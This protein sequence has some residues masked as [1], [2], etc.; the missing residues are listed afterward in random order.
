[1]SKNPNDVGGI[2][3]DRLKSFV[4]RWERL[5]EEIKGLREDQKEIMA[6]AKG[7]GFDVKTIR[8]MIK[9]REL[10]QEERDEQ[11][12]LDDLYKAALGMLN[13]TPLGDAAVR[14]LSRKSAAPPPPA[15]NGDQ[16]DIED[17]TKPAAN[18]EADEQQPDPGP[19]MEE[20][21][22]MG[23][24]AAKAGKPVTDNPFPARD[25][26]R[27]AWDEEWC[28]AAGSDGMDIPD[29]W[30]RAKKSA[31]SDERKAA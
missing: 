30:K 20:A 14:R 6:E 7:S 8:R 26:R 1:M 17:F 19:T 12:A 10:T 27:A 9:L 3:A 16:S 18:P 5:Q 15:A 21:R 4:E 25:Q 24:D 23:R 31:G 22:S 29:A 28:K 11:E 2:A 13:G